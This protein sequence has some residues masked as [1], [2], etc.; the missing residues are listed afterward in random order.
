MAAEESSASFHPVYRLQDDVDISAIALTSMKQSGICVMKGSGG[1]EFRPDDTYSEL[2]EKLRN[3]FPK[4]W[5]WMCESDPYDTIKSSWLVCMKPP[6]KSL[7]VYSDDRLP[8]GSNII[9]ACQLAKS[10]VSIS[11]R[12]LYLGKSFAIT[13]IITIVG[14]HFDSSHTQSS[15]ECNTQD[16]ETI[17][18][19]FT[20]DL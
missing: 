14:S 4:L 2:D 6:R 11:N 9:T 15:S 20:S 12:T 18:L 19:R 8:T 10:K 7:I 17:H 16:L 5:D 13:S 3:H 1:F